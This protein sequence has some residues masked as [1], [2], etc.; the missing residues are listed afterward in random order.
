M[1]SIWRWGI[2]ASSSANIAT[3]RLSD[4]SHAE[5]VLKGLER[6]WRNGVLCD[7]TLR[8]CSDAEEPVEVEVHSAVVAAVS[9]PLER[10][11]VGPMA[12]VEEGVLTLGPGVD[13]DS[14]RSVV[15]F[16]YTG[17]LE[18]TETTTFSVLEAT[19]YLDVV[20][21]K[22]LCAGLLSE[23]LSPEN[24]LGM[25]AAADRFGCPELLTEARGYVAENFEAVSQ[26]PEFLSLSKEEV[27]SI[28]EL[29][30]LR[31]SGEMVVLEA[32][33]RWTDHA[34]AERE[35][36]FGAM[37]GSK[38]VVRLSQLSPHT[39]EALSPA[40][41]TDSTSMPG[42]PAHCW[43][44]AMASVLHMTSRTGSSCA[45]ES[46]ITA[47][48][49]AMDSGDHGANRRRSLCQAAPCANSSIL[50]SPLRVLVEM[51]DRPPLAPKRLRSER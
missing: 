23:N 37:F 26:Q 49:S 16:M 5:T 30:T 48:H 19:E 32:L 33:V 6:L 50:D 28:L 39:N 20:G 2:S 42:C 9:A 46:S 27:R 21:A 36:A 22:S 47:R 18:L 25:V 51:K 41:V 10:M 29:D 44:T 40:G 7:L 15:E 4:P 12:S 34:K 14:L 24:A 31:V 35:A 43:L 13:G 8:C 38:D 17:E 1:F 3:E 11:L 45:S